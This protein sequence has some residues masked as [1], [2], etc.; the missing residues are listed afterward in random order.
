[1]MFILKVS[2]APDRMHDP[3]YA[4]KRMK[5]K[6]H[7]LSTLLYPVSVE[8]VFGLGLVWVWGLEISLQVTQAVLQL[9]L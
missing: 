2:K 4:L 7:L 5:P 9:P 1:M 6:R 3:Q 8:I